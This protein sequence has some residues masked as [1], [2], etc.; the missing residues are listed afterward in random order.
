LNK[1][2]LLFAIIVGAILELLLTH[3]HVIGDIFAGIVTGYIAGANASWGAL[4]GLLAGSLGGLIVGATL[5]LL[6]AL[7][8]PL[9]GTFSLIF[10]GG[11]VLIALLTLKAA[12]F[13]AIGGIIGSVARRLII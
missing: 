1:S 9:I 10:T 11:A 13:T 12:F 3:F 2:N 5:L 7:L 4:A 6:G 8:T